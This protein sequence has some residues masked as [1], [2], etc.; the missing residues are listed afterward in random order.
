MTLREM[1]TAYR[2]TS[3]QNACLPPTDSKQYDKNQPA[4]MA[5]NSIRNAKQ[6]PTVRR[7]ILPCFESSSCPIYR[8]PVGNANEEGGQPMP[9]QN[10]SPIDVIFCSHFPSSSS[11]SFGLPYWY[12]GCAAPLP[13]GAGHPSASC[14][15]MHERREKKFMRVLVSLPIEARVCPHGYRQ[16]FVS[17]G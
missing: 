2:N 16:S 5:S 3:H 7:R 8:K 10:E 4:A 17:C 13:T 11:K 12:I 6:L 1:C 15:F 9:E 14:I